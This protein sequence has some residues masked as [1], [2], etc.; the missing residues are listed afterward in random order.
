MR[1]ESEKCNWCSSVAH[2]ASGLITEGAT[3]LVDMPLTPIHPHLSF[4]PLFIHPGPQINHHHTQCE[5]QNISRDHLHTISIRLVWQF[6]LI[7]KYFELHPSSFYALSIS[8]NIEY[9]RREI[10][11]QL[12]GE[13]GGKGDWFCQCWLLPINTKQKKKQK[14]GVIGILARRIPWT[15]QKLFW[16]TQRDHQCESGANS[17]RI[18]CN[19][20]RGWPN[21]TWK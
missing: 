1:G 17:Y 11:S 16:P 8:E 3:S 20:T 7:V 15:P 4:S 5:R 18:L 21:A 9:S 13:R 14:D 6:K 19:L 2:P 10:K 12:M